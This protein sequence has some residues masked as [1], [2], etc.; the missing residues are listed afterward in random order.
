MFYSFL[1]A[2]SGSSR[3]HH[4][5]MQPLNKL[6]SFSNNWWLCRQMLY[7]PVKWSVW[8]RCLE[9]HEL[10]FGFLPLI[11][12][13]V[14]PGRTA[15]VN[16]GSCEPRQPMRTHRRWSR[17]LQWLQTLHRVSQPQIHS[18]TLPPLRSTSVSWVPCALSI[19]HTLDALSLII[20]VLFPQ[21]GWLK[22]NLVLLLGRI[23]WVKTFSV[24]HTQLGC[25]FP[26]HRLKLTGRLRS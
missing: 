20:A 19:S 18:Y 26:T 24:Q 9:R 6:N 5:W 25:W 3:Q 11:K 10:Q 16:L 14:T 13:S 4:G 8:S 22:E 15:G 17:I 23:F 7:L 2:I 1:K 21:Q 12:L